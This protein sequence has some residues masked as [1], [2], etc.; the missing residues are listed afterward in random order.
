MSLAVVSDKRGFGG[1][2]QFS[3][4]RTVV[5]IACL[6]KVVQLQVDMGKIAAATE[7]SKKLAHLQLTLG[8]LEEPQNDG[9]V[10][11]VAAAA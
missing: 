1:M 2:E 4:P 9:L 10:Q 3:E 6:N 8:D 11:S 5:A 7:S